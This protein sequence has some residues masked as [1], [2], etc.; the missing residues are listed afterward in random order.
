[1]PKPEVGQLRVN[2]WS[3]E[4]LQSGYCT[5][6]YWARQEEALGCRFG[7]RTVSYFDDVLPS[8]K[9]IRYRQETCEVIEVVGAG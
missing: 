1:M 9:P 2:M 7:P 4:R 3:E 5:D 6:S 8:G